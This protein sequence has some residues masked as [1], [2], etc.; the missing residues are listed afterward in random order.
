MPSNKKKERIDIRADL[1]SGEPPRQHRALLTVLGLLSDGFEVGSHIAVITQSILGNVNVPP[2]IRTAAYDV[3]EAAAPTDSDFGR[4][5]SAV[6]IDMQNS[7]PVELRVKAMRM[8][9]NLPAHR[10]VALLKNKDARI[11]LHD[12]VDS[13]SS[14]DV[15]SVAIQVFGSIVAEDAAA[16]QAMEDSSI[17]DLLLQ[18]PMMAIDGLTDD[19]NDVV[20]ASSRALRVI[21]EA[22]SGSDSGVQSF[23]P[24]LGPETKWSESM[25]AAR[26]RADLIQDLKERL[27]A[28]I[29]VALTRF[30]NLPIGYQMEIPPFL[31]AYMRVAQSSGIV[32]SMDVSNPIDAWDAPAQVFDEIACLF[33]DFIRSEE[34]VLAFSAAEGLLRLAKLNESS[35]TIQALLPSTIAVIVGVANATESH[36]RHVADQ[37]VLELLLEHLGVIPSIQKTSMFSRI[38]P[39]VAVIPTAVERVKAFSRLWGAVLDLDWG[40][41]A[42]NFGTSLDTAPDSASIAK[43]PSQLQRMLLDPYVKAAISGAPSTIHRHSMDHA[44]NKNEEKMALM[45]HHSSQDAIYREELVGTLLYA[46]LT[47]PRPVAA[48]TS[49]LASAS[50]AVAAASVLQAASAAV[51]WL[52]SSR[53]AL[54]GTKA[55]LGWDRAAGTDTTGTTAVADLWLQLLLRCVQV[56]HVMSEKLEARFGRIKNVQSRMKHDDNGKVALSL[57]DGAGAKS[58]K[59]EVELPKGPGFLA[60]E[61]LFRRTKELD[62]ELQAMLLQIS[63]NWRALH[64]A[65][66]PRAVWLCVCHM[67]LRSVVDASWNSLADALR[68]L[69]ISVARAN[70][71]RGDHVRAIGEGLLVPPDSS[72]V[73]RHHAAV[74]A[75][76]AEAEE[77]ALMSLE[78]LATLVSGNHHGS[79]HGELSSIASLLQTLA[80][81][82]TNDLFSS[83]VAT[84]RLQRIESLLKPVA[85]SGKSQKDKANQGT[86]IRS[87]DDS[88]PQKKKSKETKVFEI[89]SDPIGRA[90]MSY[91]TTLPS[92]TALS[93]TPE[94]LRYRAF[95]EQLQV[96]ALSQSSFDASRSV[97]TRFRRS[98]NAERI[99][100]DGLVVPLQLANMFEG[101]GGQA[102]SMEVTGSASPVSLT[103]RHIIV[104]EDGIIRLQCKAKN[105]MR[106]ALSRVEVTLLPGG[107]ISGSKRPLVY[108]LPELQADESTYWEVP[109]RISGFGWPV[110]QPGITLPIHVPTGL[111]TLRCRPY[112]IPPLQLLA[113]PARLLSPVEFYQRW[114]AL[115][116]RTCI[117]GNLVARKDPIKGIRNL[118]SS[119]E[120]TGLTCV[121]KVF[122]PVG[123]GVHAAFHGVAWSGES[124]AIIVT[125]EDDINGSN[126]SRNMERCGSG[127]TI[128]LFFGSESADAVSHIRGREAEVLLRLSG[129][130][131]T[132][133]SGDV[134]SLSVMNGAAKDDLSRGTQ[135]ERPL[136]TFSFLRSIVG[137]RF[138]SSVEDSQEDGSDKVATEQANMETENLQIAAL[139]Q[140]RTLRSVLVE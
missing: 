80:S 72:L 115:P 90:A 66:R 32:T 135:E 48:G 99:A 116:Y 16:S 87:P 21:L 111:P 114:Q 100:L 136:S 10:L 59:K 23:E 130:A 91:P 139:S 133:A 94:S 1:A 93:P 71:S 107:P 129:G 51:D 98:N 15:R 50:S 52:E 86:V 102:Q 96:S 62:G 68:G 75:G 54:Q 64:P 101:N 82:Q 63:S 89:S 140:W 44:G 49:S 76:A 65:V 29:A 55:C 5:S 17:A 92:A 8:V 118:L 109:L 38:P 105:L 31:V 122:M 126:A 9:S 61:S 42:S 6:L 67:K 83:P 73:E 26:F 13:S 110:I 47:H 53:I 112:R 7:C 39:M 113:P 4:I 24:H 57:D 35:S 20:I 134:V 108:K 18:V 60:L 3:V 74:M 103:L 85:T 41:S 56:R 40:A 117:L 11:A 123:G 138:E 27:H 128:R 127:T 22:S 84:A 25:L 124:I 2:F 37:A 69:T 33:G 45:I 88:L 95:L 36:Q 81:L 28:Q 79:L 70:A 106:H 137:F 12:A 46:L 121:L 14:A 34:P 131:V 119:I 97:S 78:R 77:V 19:D 43:S 104:P 125:S 30:R 132:P 58:T 120:G